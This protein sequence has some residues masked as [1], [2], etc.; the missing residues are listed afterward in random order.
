LSKAISA[1]F[2]VNESLKDNIKC[3]EAAHYLMKHKPRFTQFF[4]N[5]KYICSNDS[6]WVNLSRWWLSEL[7]NTCAWTTVFKK[8]LCRYLLHVWGELHIK[9]K[10]NFR[11]EWMEIIK[12]QG[13]QM[14]HGI[15]Y[16]NGKNIPINQQIYQMAINYTTVSLKWL[17]GHIIYQPPPLQNP[18]NFPI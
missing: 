14:F 4:E 5:V 8:F 10:E 7:E 18:N 2:V 13:C 9:S 12:D 17:N 15:T 3:Y 6:F 1:P 16:Q 11:N